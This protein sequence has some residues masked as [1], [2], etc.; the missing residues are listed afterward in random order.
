[1]P[2]LRQPLVIALAELAGEGVE[3]ITEIRVRRHV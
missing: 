3:V 2:A 1:V